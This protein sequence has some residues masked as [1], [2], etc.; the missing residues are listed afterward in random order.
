LA[1]WESQ[2]HNNWDWDENNAKVGKG[3]DDAARQKMSSLIDALLG[4]E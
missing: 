1:Q 2:S 3:V 4:F